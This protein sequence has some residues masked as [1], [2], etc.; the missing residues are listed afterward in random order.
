MLGLRVF[1]SFTSYILFNN[2]A[3]YSKEI[4]VILRKSDCE[5]KLPYS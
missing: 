4:F 1:I 3:L 2:V 5:P